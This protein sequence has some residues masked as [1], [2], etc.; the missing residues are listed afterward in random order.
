MEEEDAM[1]QAER[2]YGSANVSFQIVRI[3]EMY[4]SVGKSGGEFE[5]SSMCHGRMTFHAPDGHQPPP[6]RECL[7]SGFVSRVRKHD[8]FADAREAAI[9][10]CK[11]KCIHDYNKAS[12]VGPKLPNNKHKDEYDATGTKIAPQPPNIQRPVAWNNPVPTNPHHESTKVQ[13]PT[14]VPSMP[15]AINTALSSAAAVYG[16]SS[17]A[18]PIKTI[19]KSIPS[20]VNQAVQVKVNGTQE[21]KQPYGARAAFDTNTAMLNSKQTTV[22]S[23]ADAVYGSGARIATRS[24]PTTPQDAECRAGDN[25]SGQK[26]VRG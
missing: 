19:S 11:R 3:E 14:K 9:R 20:G 16:K 13:S 15:P 22:Q 4:C 6:Y 26:R 2:L 25:L 21:S 24:A 17:S 10:D 23:S 18:I 7:G 8:A 1:L 12:L 5:V